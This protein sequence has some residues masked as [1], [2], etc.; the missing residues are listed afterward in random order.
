[1]SRKRH[2]PEEIVA[3]LRQVEVLTAQGQSVAEAIR[4]IGVTEVSSGTSCS[5]ARSSPRSRRPRSS[6]RAGV[7]TT[8]R[9]ARTRRSAP[10]RP[11]RRSCCGRLRFPS[12]LRRPPRPWRSGL[13]CTNIQP[14]PLHGGRPKNGIGT[15]GSVAL[16]DEGRV[17]GLHCPGQAAPPRFGPDLF[18]VGEGGE[19]LKATLLG[20]EGV[21]EALSREPGQ[22]QYVPRW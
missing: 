22:T 20:L 9:S 14:G 10:S 4:S 2:R 3:K 7:G 1:M 19:G 13:S 5:T 17:A 6:S 12:Q 8:T 15:K 11:P 21:P 18:E 16:T